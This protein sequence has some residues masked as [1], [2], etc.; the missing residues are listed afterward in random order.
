MKPQQNYN[1]LFRQSLSKIWKEVLLFAKQDYNNINIRKRLKLIANDFYSTF[2]DTPIPVEFVKD[3][4]EQYDSIIIRLKLAILSVPLDL[5]ENAKLDP[6]PDFSS[7]FELDITWLELLSM[8][9]EEMIA[10]R[11]ELREADI[12]ILK[13]LTNYKNNLL[14][15]SFYNPKTKKGTSIEKKI[16]PFQISS[17]ARKTRL[18]S[19]YVA[20]RLNI[21]HNN[22]IIRQ[23]FF[24]NPFVFGVKIILIRYETT[25]DEKMEQYDFLTLV[26]Q[27]FSTSIV[28][29]LQLP[30]VQATDDLEFTFPV[31]KHEI[32]E[33]RYSN[34]LSELQSKQSNSFRKI[35][36]RYLNFTS[37][38]QLQL[39][40]SSIRFQDNVT[41]NW[42]KILLQ[43]ERTSQPRSSVKY[44][45]LRHLTQRKR[46]K[47][48]LKVLNYL[49][50]YGVPITNIN[51]A[52]HEAGTS[53]PQFL[54]LMNY[55][56]DHNLLSIFTRV[57]KIGCPVRF[58]V[59]IHNVSNES[60]HN[61]D[62]ITNKLSILPET[63]NY[64]GK[65]FV[66][67]YA[68]VPEAWYIDLQKFFVRLRSRTEIV[69]DYDLII[70]LD[71]W[72]RFSVP[73]PKDLIIDDF[74][75]DFPIPKIS[76]Y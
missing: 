46:L 10:F 21:L 20:Q 64:R 50:R 32:Q 53:E 36:L 71:S 7:I 3:E 13:T 19:D 33:I 11:F 18:S 26:K 69:L 72:G 1:L 73:L 67:V 57:S 12:K 2:K 62:T 76:K 34:N 14:S 45:S 54:D 61:L 52:A 37:V 31:E 17:I 47:L 75:V 42:F 23:Y 16:F 49:A 29:I 74:G 24:L 4:Y 60:E 65:N 8:L 41:G 39:P 44:H 70:A 51:N 56:A 55:F 38:P 22:L 6:Q 40:Q 30:S 66:F 27:K 15:V 35:N 9:F 25:F 63:R 48:A 43:L 68:A 5:F 28:R 59:L 58:G